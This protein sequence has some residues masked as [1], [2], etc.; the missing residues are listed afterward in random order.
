MLFS[1][2]AI[3]SVFVASAVAAAEPAPYKLG[4]MSMNQAFGLMRRQAGYQPGQTICGPGADCASSCGAGYSEC[5]SSDG[6][7]HC[8]NPT[9]QQTCCPDG[10][11]NSCDVGFFCTSDAEGGTWCCPDGMSL[12][13]CAAAYSLTGTLVSETASNPAST[14]SS[15]PASVTASVSGYPTTTTAEE[16]YMTTT[17]SCSSSS[18][19]ALYTTSYSYSNITVSTTTSALPTQFTGGAAHLG[20]PAL[21]LAAA[22]AVL[23]L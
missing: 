11:G 7:L 12:A 10:T 13:A 6:D 17:T 5:A 22:G 8:Y 16:T 23:A 19:K 2:F 3:S 1:T 15:Y 20:F 4:K 18:S 21:A 9:V 14:P